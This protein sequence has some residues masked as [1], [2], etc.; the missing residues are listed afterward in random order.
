MLENWLAHQRRD[1]FWRHGS[2]CEDFAAVAVPA[3]VLAGW[4]DGYRNTPLDAAAGLGAHAKAILGSWVHKFPHFA[5]PQTRMDFHDGAMRF[6]APC[7]ITDEC[8]VG[9]A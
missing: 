4:A 9:K 5:W 3:L 6:W 2:I 8:G 1:A 7:L